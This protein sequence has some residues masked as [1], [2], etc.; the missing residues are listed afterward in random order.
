MIGKVGRG[1]LDGKVGREYLDGKIE[2]E[3]GK[4]RSEGQVG[5][6]GW[7]VYSFTQSLA[8][9]LTHFLL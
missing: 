6:G 8:L 9:S 2:K 7:K 1:R 3:D 4:G 5:V